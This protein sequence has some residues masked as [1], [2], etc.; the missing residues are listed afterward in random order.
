MNL[1]ELKNKIETIWDK[2]TKQEEF[3]KDEA[4]GVAYEVIDLLDNAEIRVAQKNNNGEWQVNEWIKKAILL[5]FIKNNND[6]VAF[7]GSYWFDKCENKFKNCNA[8]KFNNTGV[9]AVPGSFVRKGSFFEKGVVIMPSFVNV[10]AYVGERTMIDSMT[11][12][13]SCC[14]IGKKCHISANVCIG[15]VLEPLQSSPVII[16]DNCF[17]GAGCVITE[18]IIVEEGSVIASGVVLSSGVKIINRETG[19]V[20][21]GKIPQYSVVVPGTYNSINNVA[22]NCAVIINKINADIKNKTAINELLR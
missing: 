20:V 4:V 22:I 6:I 3:N 16:E 10:G 12:I 7:D 14:Q 2:K 13:G 11:T 15:G 21:K 5:S 18:G 9:R 8:E 1:E 19:E 17:I